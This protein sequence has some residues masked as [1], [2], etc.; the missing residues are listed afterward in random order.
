MKI[1]NGKTKRNNGGATPPLPPL[2]G[3]SV[4]CI[5]LKMTY[6]N[7]LVFI[8]QNINNER[9]KLTVIIKITGKKKK[10]LLE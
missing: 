9:K 4:K 6:F 3:S 7:H 1:C 10:H 8:C 2:K 5:I